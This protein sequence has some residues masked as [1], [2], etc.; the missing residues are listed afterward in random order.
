MSPESVGEA[1]DATAV[2]VTAAL[3]DA[4]RTTDTMITVT[5]GDAGDAAAEGTDYATV[6]TV[7]VTI[8]AGQTTGTESFSLDP[9]DDDV[10][11]ADETL[12]VTGST[13][14]T[15]LSV[16]ST[17]VTIADNDT[18]GVTV[19]P[20]SVPVAEGGDMT[21]TVVLD[22]TP[23]GEV[24]VTPTVTGSSDVTVS[25]EVLTF[26]TT[27]WADEQTVTVSAAADDDAEDETAAVG[28][29]VAGADY[30]DNSVTADDV[31]VTVDDDET[32]STEV[33][34]TV[35]P[36]SVDEADDA[37]TV[38][39]TAT[40]N[41]APRTT[42]TTITVTVGDAGDAATEGTDYTTVDTATVT[43]TAGQT[44]GTESFS[45]DPTDDDL[46]ESDEAL[47]VTGSNT[48]AGLMVTGT[49]VTIS[50]D[51]TRGVTVAP[52]SL[53][54]TEG[55]TNRY[56]VVLDSAPTGTVTVTPTVTGSS[57]VTVSE[58]AL[59]FTTTTW[60]DE[61]T[62]T[63]SA[64]ADADAEDD[65]ATV[66]HTVAGADYGDSSVTADSVSVAVDDDE[67][68]STEVELTVSPESVGE[69]D[70]ATTVTVTATLNDAPRTTDTT[71]TVAVG[72]AGDPATEGTDYAT[73]GTVTVTIK[74]GQ[75]SGTESFSLDPTG[76][77]VDEADETLSVKG[78][79]PATG[80]SVSSTGVTI[81]DDDTR[82]VTVAPTSLPVA[83]GGDATYTVV[84]GSAPTGAVTVTPTVTGSSDVT[85]SDEVLTFTTTT[86]SN[87]QTVT[88]SAAADIDAEDD[89]ATVTH[90]V[91][92]AD[93][94]DN[95]VTADSVSMAVDDDETA[96]T[97]VELTVSPESVAEADDATTV[98]VTATLNDAPR[99]TDTAITVTVG[100]ASDPA[101]EGTDYATVDT[102][103]VT[104][105]AEQ[106]SGAETFPLDPTG[107]AVDEADETLSVK[108][109]TPATGLSVSS[110]TVTI[111]DDDDRGVTVSP[112]SL[113][114]AEGADAT[115]TVVLD[116]APTGEVTV[117]PTVTGS[118][119]V[120][121]SDEVL[122]FTA[123]TW[124]DEQTV[125]VSAAADDDAEDDTAAVGHVVAGAD[126]GDNS[127]TAD[128]VSVTVDDDE[129]A[130]PELTVVLGEPEHDDQDASGT[131]TLGDVLSYTARAS[132]TGNV[133]LSGVKLSDL[134]VNSSGRECGTVAIGGSCEISGEYPVTQADV[135]AGM[136]E[137]TA[138]GT[139]TEL[140]GEETAS[141]STVVEQ[142]RELTLAKSA[143][144]NGFGGTG[145]TLTYSYEVS[146]SG[147]VTLTGTVSI[148]DDKIA[149]EEIS[150]G[151]V[152]TGGL[153]PGGKVTCS[154]SYETEQAD[155]DGSGVTNRATASLGGV[156]AA[157]VEVRV[158][159]QAPQG[160]TTQLTL[161]GA[162]GSEDAGTL[163][164]TVTLAPASVQ[165]VQV[166]YE[167]G[168]ETAAAGTD[169]TAA[170]GTL[171][172]APGATGGTIS[173]AI[174]D[175]A[176][177]E[178][179]ETFTVSLSD[180]VN[181]AIATGTTTVT[182]TDND[183]RGVT[184][185]PTT[186]TVTEGS[187]N[188]Y[189]VELASEPTGTV[190]VTPSVTGSTDVTVPTEALTFT[191]TTWDDEQ[192][193]TVSAGQ[194]DD[195]VDDAATV[196]HAVAGADYG[197]NSVTADSVSVAVDDDETESTEVELT[198]SPES[199]GEADDATTVTVT[200]T[201]NGALRTSDTTVT[202]T[203]G[204]AGDPATEGTDYATVDTVTVTITAG[205]TSGTETFSLEPTN[206]GLPETDETLSV[207]GST[208]AAGLS[209]T[210]T[211]VTISDNHAL[212]GGGGSGAAVPVEVSITAV[213]VEV[214]E[215]E[216]AE[217][218]LTRSG[219][220][221][222]ALTVP[223][224]VSEQG[225][226][227]AGAAPTEVTFAAGADTVSL[228]VATAD[229]ETDEPDGVITATLSGGPGYVLGS[230]ASA[231]VAVTD[232]DAAPRLTMADV[233]V[234]ESAG[235]IAFT[236]QMSAASGHQVTVV[237]RSED[238]T[239]TAGEDYEAELGTL[240]LE[241]GQ[242]S[243]TITIPIFDDALDEMDETFSMVLSRPANA[244]VAD[245][246]ATGTILDDD[247]T[248]A[249]AWLVR[250]GRA[251]AGEVVDAVVERVTGGG[252]NGPR[253]RLAGRR[254]RAAQGTEA[255]GQHEP[256]WRVWEVPA[257]PATMEVAEL[258][259]GSWFELSAGE[260]PGPVGGGGQWSAWGRGGTERI[261]GKTDQLT[262]QGQVSGVVAGVDYDWG[263]AVAGVSAAY[264]GGAGEV[265]TSARAEGGGARAREEAASWLV[266]V[267]PYVGV[268][269]TDRA[270]VWGVL[271]HGRGSMTMANGGGEEEAAIW[272]TMGA[273]GVRGELLRRG[274]TEGFGLAVKADGMVLR[275]GSEAVGRLPEASADV[276]RARVVLAGTVDVLRGPGG[277]LTPTLEVG[278]R[279]DGGAAET[280]AGLEVGGGLR[281]VYPAWGVAAAVS[282]RLLVAHEESGFE[283]WGAGGALRVAPGQTGGGPTLTV[284]TAWGQDANGVEQLWSQG[285]GLPG[286][287][288]AQ[289]GAAGG[290][291]LAAELGYGF[292]VPGG[293]ITP[294]A[295]VD[296][297]GQGRHTY[298]LGSRLVLSPSFNLSLQ[299]ERREHVGT[300]V[301]E[302]QLN[303]ALRW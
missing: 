295:G 98:T 227:V 215:G 83:E 190:T 228:S 74:A 203:V 248:L 265:E 66:T 289:D 82:G 126:Y 229:D 9:T 53:P 128:S 219:G 221:A 182:I 185:S 213:A 49:T 140:S 75:T 255:V 33:E 208:G 245:G 119:D 303:A 139:A 291:R 120:T 59:T 42:D 70:D 234:A 151:T 250:F 225:G 116:S 76:D 240:V 14:A 260:V 3:N 239:A 272:M 61:H 290:G 168:D 275:T 158:P 186:L 58:D 173:V 251:V 17:T 276:Q 112:T 270:E 261:A 189:T 286:G 178:D 243:G 41:D 258:V 279:Y 72:D 88:V 170:T 172:M 167:T 77:A 46:D 51:D 263:A 73:V 199:V 87:E 43:I 223:V 13:T 193:V 11:E 127:V 105:T 242:T 1:D 35:S 302:L 149:S 16:S 36:E 183:T 63:V 125:T 197:D 129:T 164:L 280:G 23:T 134:L 200:A 100:D 284:S 122:T 15:G 211:M 68:A 201:L 142:E 297:D 241:P 231:T 65:T 64:D 298:R 90:T 8:T 29:V 212:G 69:A 19:A 214:E 236:V 38:A 146:N 147:T 132:N 254:L 21:Y 136:V 277:V 237:C 285:V 48:A 256:E 233:E 301:H 271:G 156:E 152:P 144:E 117:T 137:N 78:S 232:N 155:V 37:T 175:D 24:T 5:V 56:T 2:T 177:D 180:A 115:Y 267:H 299:A 230:T 281:Y 174:T 216:R 217:F 57:D 103:T 165:T 79:T 202:V 20:T 145:E 114:V 50:D 121:V 91:A 39:V 60:A 85:V 12:S 160:Q 89:T 7:T 81:E 205:E 54:V 28:H 195:A 101:T 206:D 44:T 52:T 222:G 26:T 143:T 269:V 162:G 97:E 131:V 86:W 235:E 198:V 278:A 148:T 264:H 300:P 123:S 130:A 220:S 288:A 96:S 247:P 283:Q 253:A 176:V 191:A 109:S 262:V 18:R 10:D 110:T 47:S 32:A 106:T 249:E 154:G 157:A 244:T 181:A 292:A 259:A 71:I 80:L 209:V 141:R 296:L 67:T 224:E 102:V 179:A 282:G 226:V 218:T 194:D 40:L 95:S 166:D 204:S 257:E 6:G 25:D 246:E 104:I 163:K 4:P 268:E 184:V 55:S 273:V 113:P 138:T 153:G 133:A 266:S 30:E 118:S 135:D 108:G 45:L 207:T 161:N 150:C 159:W 169:Y 31:A 93:Y 94:E 27:T 124:A 294:F 111:V 252:V 188:S 293:S 107:D 84:L 171:T 238:M 287:P 34:L 22:S 210:A 99:T 62:V 196:S 274:E 192:T 92:G 187:T